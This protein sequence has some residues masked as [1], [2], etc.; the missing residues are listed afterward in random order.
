MGPRE[1]SRLCAM[2][3][4]IGLA[5]AALPNPTLAAGF[6]V[7]VPS[8]NGVDDTANLQAGLDACVAE[9]PGCTVQL[10]SGR[11]LTRQLV[12]YNF[13]GTFRGE[14]KDATTIEALPNLPVAARDISV[15]GECPPDTTTCPWPSLIIFVDGDIQV[16]DLSIRITAPPGTATTG[17]AFFGMRITTLVD[18]LRFMGRQPTNVAIDRVSV[19]GL[20]DYSDS[21]FGKQFGF[22]VG[23]NVLNGIIFAGEFP[24]SSAPFDYYFTSGS[25]TVRNSSF[26]TMLDGVS[27]DGFLTSSHVTI[28][29]SP[30]AGNHFEN[31]FVG[32]DMESAQSSF[33]DVS[34]N[35]SSGLFFAAWVVPWQRV[36]VP[37]SPSQYLIHDNAFLTTE[38]SA[39]GLLLDNEPTP[40]IQANVWNNTFELQ[41]AS[42]DGIDLVK[43]SGARILNN[44]IMGS[45]FNAIGLYGSTTGS[46]V[47]RNDVAG[48]TSTGPGQIFLGPPTTQNVVVCSSRSD[49]VLDL[50]TANNVVGCAQAAARP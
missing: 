45:G 30:S 11:Y 31:V 26:R 43:T 50:G 33:F 35:T 48:F 18:A 38:P 37:S 39:V 16:S 15:Q 10:S 22:P 47:V 29:G 3:A 9:G 25:L 7:A 34:Y 12:T 8:P 13:Q 4:V 28:G 5:L 6:T 27:E 32:M 44:T 46:T 14:G 41:N 2:P 19:E 23:F 24:R 20:P 36:F 40:W 42:S 21:S 49:T 17:W 1:A